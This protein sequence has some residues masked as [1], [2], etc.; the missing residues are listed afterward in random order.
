MTPSDNGRPVRKI[1]VRLVPPEK[2]ELA[3]RTP[4]IKL[5]SA[6]K[7]ADV[8]G[9]GGMAKLL[10]EDEQIRVNGEVCTQRGKKLRDG[11]R[12][13]LGPEEFGVKQA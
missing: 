3:I 11:D 10:I 2:K 13:T 7:L 5:D 9:S 8:V 4:F 6:L 12:V 1:K